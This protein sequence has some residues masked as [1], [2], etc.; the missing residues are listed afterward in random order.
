M[1]RVAATQRVSQPIDSFSLQVMEYARLRDEIAELEK[2]QK[3]LRDSLMDTVKNTG[4]SDAKGHIWL[5]LEGIDGVAALQA[6]RRAKVS[7][8]DERAMDLLT[9]RGLTDRCTKLVRIVDDEEL[10]RAKAEELLSDDD[11][12]SITDVSV[13]WAL[14]VK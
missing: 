10:M 12:D 4:E 11:L 2:R 9:D 8:N 7:L 5:E 13:T 3:E 1:A 14:R 6:E